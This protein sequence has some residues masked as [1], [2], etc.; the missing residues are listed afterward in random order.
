M[1]TLVVLLFIFP[2]LVWAKS[3]TRIS[4]IY[5]L[6]KMNQDPL[7]IQ[8]TEIQQQDSESFTSKAKIEDTKGQVVMTETVVVRNGALVSQ[9]VQQLQSKEAWDL[10]V[11]G[12]KASFDTY[13]IADGGGKLK[14]G[15]GKTQE[16]DTFING[17]LIEH[18]ISRNWEKLMAAEIVHTAFSVLELERTVDFQFEKIKE[19]ERDKKKVLVLKMKPR[20]FFISVLVDP[21]ILE[22]DVSTKQLVY[23]KGRTPL[24]VLKSGVLKP[25]DAEISY[26]TRDNQ[27]D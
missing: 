24:K 8:T 2:A 9:S 7:F 21:M 5:E 13:K 11:Q 3:Q 26:E 17:P 15:S 4:K 27:T 25:F 22:F 14:V 10:N 12:N 23:F 18:F 19:S 1:R 16:V 6:G 20:N